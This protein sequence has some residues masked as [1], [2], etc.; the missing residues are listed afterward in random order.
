MPRLAVTVGALLG[1]LGLDP[2]S[3]RY[4]SLVLLVSPIAPLFGVAA[5][6]SRRN[7]PAWEIL[8]ATPH[9]GLGL[10]LRRTLAVLVLLT[11]VLVLVGWAAGG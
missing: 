2:M 4:P 6:W 3:P 8:A 5:A 7:D 10:L 11:P 1:V 9:A